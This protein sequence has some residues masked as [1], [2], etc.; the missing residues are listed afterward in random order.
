VPALL[1]TVSNHDGTTAASSEF[2]THDLDVVADT[3]DDE[4]R[5]RVVPLGCRRG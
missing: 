4:V 5:I 2:G 1:G 3:N